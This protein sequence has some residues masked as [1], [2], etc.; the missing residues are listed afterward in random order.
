MWWFADTVRSFCF[1]IPHG[2]LD[3]ETKFRPLLE[4]SCKHKTC[5][6]YFITLLLL[7]FV[8]LPLLFFF[9]CCWVWTVPIL[10]LKMLC[11]EMSSLWNVVNFTA[12]WSF[13]FF[14][15]FFFVGPLMWVKWRMGVSRL[16]CSCTTVNN[17]ELLLYIDTD[18]E[19]LLMPLPGA[20]HCLSVETLIYWSV[21]FS[22]FYFGTGLVFYLRAF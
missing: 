9:C 13:S 12:A 22:L 11:S 5:L 1:R 4:G 17:D 18:A 10:G 19:S 7:Q 2:P 21:L 14:L 16:L 15:F 6:V 3:I 20:Y 8:L